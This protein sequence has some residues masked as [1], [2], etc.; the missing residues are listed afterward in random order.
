MPPNQSIEMQACVRIAIAI[1]LL[2]YMPLRRAKKVV[3]ETGIMPQEPSQDGAIGQLV[4]PLRDPLIA[5]FAKPWT[6][7]FGAFGAMFL[8]G[9]MAIATVGSEPLHQR[10]IAVVVA[11]CAAYIARSVLAGVLELK[12]KWLTAGGRSQYSS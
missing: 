12:T 4:E 7:F 1:R 2:M 5:Q 10:I 3:G 8:L 11:L 6:E 9:V